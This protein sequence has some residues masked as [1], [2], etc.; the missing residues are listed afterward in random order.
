MKKILL[1]ANSFLPINSP[2]SHRYSSF[3]KY[4]TELG[5]EV[6]V[7]TPKW[8]K[9]SRSTL[10]NKTGFSSSSNLKASI[11]SENYRVVRVP[12]SDRKELGSQ[13][14]QKAI[15]KLT[16]SYATYSLGNLKEQM[17]KKAV[18]ICKNDAIDLIISGGVPEYITEVSGL[19]AEQCNISW[20][21]EYRD[22]VGQTP[23]QAN[24]LMDFLRQKISR[25][26]YIYKDNKMTKTAA[27]RI[28]V[29]QGLADILRERNKS[30]VHVVMNGF[31]S[32]DFDFVPNNPKNE[33]LT[34]I[35]GG[36]IY[37]VHLP[38]VFIQGLK[39]FI[40]ESPELANKISVKFFGQSA[41]FIQP[42]VANFPYN[43]VFEYPG[44]VERKLLLQ[45]I[46]NSDI[47]L[48]LSTPAK[49]IATSKIFECLASTKNVLSVPGDK[50]ITSEMILKS[51]AGLV[52]ETPQAVKAC[53]ENWMTEWL[54]I[55][56]V[57]S[58][59][60]IEYINQYS[61]KEQAKKLAEIIDAL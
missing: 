60:D 45:E 48:F 12:F 61:R 38:D 58:N 23:I 16:L 17:L 59:L 43:D 32:D 25:K 3:A 33:K 52:A 20:V 21:A 41:T 31:E 4:L 1:I 27:A 55:G 26:L 44:N 22:V 39:L 18:D 8:T 5:Y 6:I 49:G 47:L 24:G 11:E 2:A 28:T 29:S 30:P 42:F 14:Y 9:S 37:P 36:T 10:E 56:Y 7:L 53:L 35:Y 50:D 13:I 51:K 57:K 54:K 34:I 40:D 19:V 46:D 15:A